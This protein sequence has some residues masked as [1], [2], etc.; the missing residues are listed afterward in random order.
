MCF[1]FWGQPTASLRKVENVGGVDCCRELIP[2][3]KHRNC[4]TTSGSTS[5][6]SI[7][8]V[9][10]TAAYAQPVRAGCT[11]EAGFHCFFKN[12][13][14]SKLANKYGVST[15]ECAAHIGL[16]H[17]NY[18]IWSVSRGKE[19][20][21]HTVIFMGYVPKRRASNILRGLGAG[22]LCC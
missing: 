9:S 8:F 20:N 1:P 6:A 7:E 21:R 19:K 5:H 13:H 14:P 10:R 15:A 11:R 17:V 16:T 2:D 12:H 4:C 22:C 18:D 3:P